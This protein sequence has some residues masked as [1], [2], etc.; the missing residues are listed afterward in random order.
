M[1]PA[2]L[3]ALLDRLIAGWEN[4]VVEF[5]TASTQYSAEK[6]GGYVSAIANEASQESSVGRKRSV[7]SI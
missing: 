2:E 7:R 3:S 5:K 4:E 1:N 6:T